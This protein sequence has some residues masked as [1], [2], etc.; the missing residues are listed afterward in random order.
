MQLLQAFLKRDNGVLTH[1]CRMPVLWRNDQKIPYVEVVFHSYDQQ[2]QQQ[3]GTSVPESTGN[4]SY[5]CW[6]LFLLPDGAF[7]LS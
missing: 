2:Q 3:N 1:N 4:N 5:L 6:Q 7:V